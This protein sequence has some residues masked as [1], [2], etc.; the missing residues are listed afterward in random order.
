[1]LQKIEKSGD[2]FRVS[3]PTTLAQQC[4]IDNDTQVSVK[5]RDNRIVIETTDQSFSSL[6]TFWSEA[7]EEEIHSEMYFG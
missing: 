6:M 2:S 3:I 7:N 1:M 5:V 4:G